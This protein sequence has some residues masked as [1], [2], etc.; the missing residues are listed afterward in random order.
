[1]NGTGVTKSSRLA[2][3][4]VWRGLAALSVVAMHMRHD[5]PGGFRE[6]PFFVFWFLSEFGYLGV[7]LFVI[8]SGFCIH[9]TAALTA[10]RNGSYDLDWLA[11]WRRRFWR[12][13][14]TYV[15]AILFS[16]ILVHQIVG[17]PPENDGLFGWDILTH[18]FLFHNLTDEFNTGMGNGVFWS[19]GME[20]QL[21]GLYFVLLLFI[22]RGRYLNA[23]W[24]VG[25][26]T[27]L[28]RLATPWMMEWRPDLGV[29]HLGSWYHW[30]TFYWL[31]WVLGALA[32]DAF[33]G[34]RVLPRWCYSWRVAVILVVPGMMSNRVVIELLAN[35]GAGLPWMTGL[36]R[37]MPWMD[38][39]QYIGELIIAVAFFCAINAGLSL[40]SAGRFPAAVT[41]VFAPVG[42]ISYS[43]YLIHVP[44]LLVLERW[45][46]QPP[47]PEGWVVRWLIY[48][49][50]V[51]AVAAL[52]Y[53]I[54][55][56]RFLE[57]GR[58][59]NPE[60][61]VSNGQAVTRG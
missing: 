40:E 17:I 53:Q 33:I 29:F 14:P 52:F 13:Y 58:T 22:R 32:V 55:E 24:M 39:I 2:S 61:V 10:A 20:E 44:V 1:M 41:R 48:W 5:A 27:V 60:L 21:Y 9:R 15:V 37:N 57:A 38:S 28:W 23:M 8:I 45:W 42:R 59:R 6:H 7:S 36:S 31:H 47:T 18:L 56:K 49:P 54:V 30:P 34:N 50:A 25:A 3:I 11:F 51:L 4:D 43:L 46:P 19:L 26:V 35:S 12:L 16:V